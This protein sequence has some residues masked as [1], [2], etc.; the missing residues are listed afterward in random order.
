MWPFAKSDASQS[1]SKVDEQLEAFVGAVRREFGPIAQ[2][3]GASLHKVDTWILGFCAPHAVVTVGAYPGHYRSICVKL[4]YRDK[5]SVPSVRDETDIGLANIDLFVTGQLSV[6]FK[7]SRE[8]WKP[9]PI[10]REVMALAAKTR[11]IAM[12]FLKSPVADWEGVRK[13]IAER[14][15]RAAEERRRN[16]RERSM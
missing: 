10:E 4:R 7:Q 6:I 1:D 12:P 9:E 5:D 11:E 2:D 8:S 13:M 15:E 3:C 16:A 14:I